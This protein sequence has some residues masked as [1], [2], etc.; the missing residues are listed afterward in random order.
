[1]L[2]PE[3]WLS[4]WVLGVLGLAIGSFLNVVI[5]RLPQLLERDWLGDAAGYLQ[6]EAAMTRV[7]GDRPARTAELARQGEA[8][9]ADVAA[10]PAMSLSKPRSRC[11]QCGHTLAWH[12][13]IPLLGWLRLGGKCA[14]CGTRISA[15]YPIVE[16]LTGALF[17]AAAVQAG[18]TAAAAVYCAALALL[19]AAAFI[20]L[21]TTLLPDDL[22]LP[23]IGLG[24]VAAWQRWIPVTL[25][26]AALGAFFGYFSLWFVAWTYK[27]VRGVQGM[28][29]GDFKLLAGLGALL[30]W[31]ALPAIILLSSAVGAAVGVFMIVA[32]G[33]GRNVPIPFGPYLAGGGVCA[34]F[35]GQQ[36]QGLLP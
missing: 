35:F 28:A 23:L 21:D 6:D 29:E 32:R 26:D 22:T 31:Q 8:L 10:L 14:G 36:L 19:V 33:H 1:M 7:L 18:P 30:G 3:V 34:L 20:D 5:H 4:P 2:P 25:A 9:A 13:N 11:P 17:A 24:L 27:L 12:E 15:R 16:A